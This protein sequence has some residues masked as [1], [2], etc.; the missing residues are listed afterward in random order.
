[1]LKISLFLKY[2]YSTITTNN[3]HIIINILITVFDLIIELII[4]KK[5]LSNGLV[6]ILIKTI[7]NISFIILTFNNIDILITV[8][9]EAEHI[10]NKAIELGMNSKDVYHFDNND[11]ASDLIK[12][13]ANDGD[14]VLVKASNGMHFDEIVQE[15]I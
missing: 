9:T 2:L 13:I 10:F 12:Q 14:I 3:S 15:I 7:F 1:M 8:G 4:S 6:T 11:D 5:Q